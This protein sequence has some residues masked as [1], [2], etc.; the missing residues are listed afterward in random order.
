MGAVRLAFRAELRRRW[1]S[2]LTIALLIAFIG[3][4]VLGLVAA[5][6]RTATAFP[7]LLAVTNGADALVYSASGFDVPPAA[8]IHLPQVAE[9]GVVAFPQAELTVDGRTLP[10][11][12]QLSAPASASF[13]TTIERQRLLQGRRANPGAPNQAVVSYNELSGVRLGSVVG[14]RFYTPKQAGE[15]FDSFGPIPVPTGA[16]VTVHVVGVVASS[17]DFP[18]G[19]SPSATLYVTPALLGEVASTSAVAYVSAVQLRGGPGDIASFESAVAHLRGGADLYVSDVDGSYA[20]IERSIHLQAVA[21]WI[22][23][24]IAGAAGLVVIAQLLARQAAVDAREYPVLRTIGMGTGDLF[25]LGLMSALAIALVGGL[26]AIAIAYALSPLTPI[27]EAAV[28]EPDPGLAFD[29][30]ALLLGALAVFVVVAAVGA[31]PARLEASRRRTRSDEGG[32]RGPQRPSLVAGWLARGGAPVSAVVGTRLAFERGRG[33][34]A[35]PTFAAFCGATL[36][37]FAL[38]ATSVFGASLGHL[39]DSPRLYGGTF[40]L[41]IENP[42]GTITTIVP[43]LLRYPDISQLSSGVEDSVRIQGRVIDTIA[44]VSDKGPLLTPPVISGHAVDGPDQIVL[45]ETTLR[46]VKAHVGGR[47]KVTIGHRAMPF[48]VVGTAA[49][50]VFGAQG[51]LG[52]GADMSLRS[53]DRLAGCTPGD[54]STICILDGAVL[55]VGPGPGGAGTLARLETAYGNGA[56]LPVVPTSLVNFGQSSDLP[57][58]LGLAM[59]L[60]GAAAALH[61]LLVSVTRRRHDTGMLK[62]LGLIGR[63]V[64]A[65]VLWQVTAVVV[66]SLVVGVPFGIVAGRFAWN[67]TASD[68]GVISDVVIPGWQVATI[69]AGSI[70]AGNLLA[71]VPA[72]MS[73]RL[74]PAPL[75]RAQ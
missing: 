2:W 44:E 55:N 33:Q 27:G 51:G 36:A 6:R 43:A 19:G 38:I 48:T 75:L 10:S 65:V 74:R 37:V 64:R 25:R 7:R 68:F 26:G 62:T 71:V 45:G 31:I 35:V 67:L 1:R 57:L 15:I 11:Y 54:T 72:A 40:D 47:I 16:S 60:F 42:G 46:Q 28:A 20:V 69:V 3:A 50:P 73:S 32:G 8:V 53:Y 22:L 49:F 59:A 29:S 61:F 34:T 52:T 12:W 41:Q 4:T 63:Q 17:A 56:V 5:G 21:W 58:V 30:V 18:S 70:A 13:G 14:L 9:S 24:A 66:V 23:A 39:L